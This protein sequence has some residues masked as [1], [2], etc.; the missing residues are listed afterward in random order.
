MTHNGITTNIKTVLSLSPNEEV[1]NVYKPVQYKDIKGVLILTDK[2]L[3]FAKEIGI[4]SKSLKVVFSIG[5]L[6]LTEMQVIS[7]VD[8][9]YIKL[10]QFEVFSSK[11]EE[12]IG[13]YKD[14]IYPQVQ[15]SKGLVEYKGRWMLPEEKLEREQMDR[16]LVKIKG[17]WITPEEKFECEQ[18]ERGLVKYKGTWLKPEEKY[19]KEMLDKGMV[20][21]EG[22]W[23]TPEEKFEKEKR[24]KG[25]VQFMGRWGT[26]EQVD[27]WKKLY[28]G[29]TNDFM[30]RSP[31]EFEG[32]IANLFTKMG[33]S[34]LITSASAD[35]GADVIAKKNGETIAVQVKRYKQDSQV[36]VQDVNQVLGS[37]YRYN[38][39]KAVVVT[40]SNFTSAAKKLAKSA[41]VEL[42]NRIKLY[43]MI[44]Q[45]F[46][47]DSGPS[48]IKEI[49]K[50]QE[51]A[52]SK[53]VD[54]YR[55]SYS[56]QE[57][58]RYEDAIE[59]WDWVAQFISQG[60][61]AGL[62][63]SGD[64]ELWNNKGICYAK[65]GRFKE[66]IECYNKA[67]EKNPDSETGRLAKNNKALAQEKLGKPFIPLQQRETASTA[68]KSHLPTPDFAQNFNL[69]VK[70]EN[71]EMTLLHLAENKEFVCPTSCRYFEEQYRPDRFRCPKGLFMVQRPVPIETLVCTTVLVKVRNISS[72][73]LYMDFFNFHV[74]DS[75][76]NQFDPVG[77]N[78]TQALCTDL[79]QMLPSQYKT[80]GFCLYNDAQAIC[81]LCFP[82]LPP[83]TKI[84]R[85]IYR[86]DKEKM[87]ITIASNAKVE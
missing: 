8:A 73:E 4:I 37:M 58:G 40:T 76:G 44:E 13:F 27:R 32:F 7:T 28:A 45:Y 14:V 22:Q 34:T 57:L 2:R 33:Y 19:E 47:D 79:S 66:A 80:Y 72:R 74:F 38:A 85:L 77:P 64:E 60:R 6:D 9:S 24:A 20:K 67:L 25:L 3:I 15:R 17:E 62:K 59:A 83:Q 23:I 11:I 61:A 78:V 10:G 65:L 50:E 51:E 35:Y 12:L 81:L 52:H 46:F 55:K 68:T 26:V 5:L 82:Q 31:R 39:T 63:I 36:G 43:A 87:D 48:V 42:W 69:C 49:V 1:A 75:H 16:G 54:W 29:L 56:L 70:G 18:L 71:L 53:L 21:F 41:P 30:D 86:Q 84:I